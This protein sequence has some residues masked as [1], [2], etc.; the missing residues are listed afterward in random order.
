M[1]A[2]DEWCPS[3]I[4][5]QYYFVSLVGDMESLWRCTFRKFAGDTWLN[6]AVDTQSSVERRNPIQRDCDR[7]ERWTYANFMIRPSA[8]SCVWVVANLNVDTGWAMSGP[9]CAGG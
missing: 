9:G 1:E 7:V 4:W 2:S 8:G 5:D 3:E 6:D